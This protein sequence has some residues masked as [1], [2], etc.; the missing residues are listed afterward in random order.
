MHDAVI[1]SEVECLREP[2]GHTHGVGH[3]C[4]AALTNHDIERIRGDVILG[5]VG[6]D[7]FDAGRQR[8]GNDRMIEPGRNQLLKFSD[9]LVDAFRG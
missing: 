3:R 6:G 2:G 4:R 1:R 7:A 5:E 8:R 9:Q